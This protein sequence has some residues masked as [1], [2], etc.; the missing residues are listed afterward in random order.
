MHWMAPTPRSIPQNPRRCLWNVEMWH[1]RTWLVGIAVMG[2][3]LDWMILVVFYNL[4]D[5]MI[6]WK[7]TH[8]QQNS[9]YTA[10]SRFAFSPSNH[11]LGTTAAQTAQSSTLQQCSDQRKED[12]ISMAELPCSKYTCIPEAEQKRGQ[13]CW[14]WAWHAG[15]V[16]SSSHWEALG[17]L[18]TSWT[19]HD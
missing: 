2:W 3:W 4:N 17:P 7:S 13:W 10:G 9:N 8:A 14:V 16:Q 12:A 11:Q 18:R 5:C 6:L 1:C 19:H 15:L